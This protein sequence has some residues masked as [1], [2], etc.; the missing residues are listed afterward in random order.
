MSEENEA[1]SNKELS[2]EEKIELAKKIFSTLPVDER[3]KFANWCHEQVEKGAGEFLG[4]K[5]QKMQD[6]LSSFIARAQDKIVNTGQ[7]IYRGTNNTV[8][9]AIENY[10]EKRLKNESEKLDDA[11]GDSDKEGHSFFSE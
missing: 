11:T 1:T 4:Q 7:K 8:N 10:E 9:S 6:D 2:Q 3:A 5:M